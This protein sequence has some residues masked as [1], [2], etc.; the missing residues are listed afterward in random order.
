MSARVVPTFLVVGA[1]RSGTTAVAEALRAH[2]DVFVTRPKEPHYWALHDRPLDFAG[3]GDDISVNA[4]SVTSLGEYLALYDAAPDAVTALGDASVSSLYYY[5]RAIP[6]IC[7]VNPDTRI[8]VLL[9][10]P[11]DRAYSAFSY[12]RA[13]GN[14][15]EDDFRDALA[16]EDR[17]VA[18]HW[19]HLWHYRRMSLYADALAAFRQ[20]FGDDGVHVAF[21]DDLQR[22]V[23]ATLAGILRFIG[24]TDLPTADAEVRRVNVSGTPRSATAQRA[25]RALTR[26]GHLKRVGRRLT[27]RAFRERIRTSLVTKDDGVTDA[28]RQDLAPLFAADRRALATLLP[29]RELPP[30]VIA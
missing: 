20:S 23:T 11:V 19:H 25:V 29:D 22:D 12:L 8:V 3:P 21:Y 24:V 9:R 6:E 4:R 10:E 30:W 16:D 28:V 5:E 2:P 14:E 18:A 15:P 26:N 1:A 27:S 17:R 13:R 7:R